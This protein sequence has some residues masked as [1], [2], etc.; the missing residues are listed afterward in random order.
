VLLRLAAAVAGVPVGLDDVLSGTALGPVWRRVA[1]LPQPRAEA[2]WVDARE[3]DVAVLLGLAGHSPGEQAAGYLR[4]VLGDHDAATRRLSQ[5]R[6]GRG[7][8]PGA[9]DGLL[10]EA[11]RRVLAARHPFADEVHPTRLERY[12]KCPFAFYLRDVLRLEAPEEP[13]EGLEMD[14]LELGTLAHAILQRTFQ[15][16]ICEHLD[17]PG[18]LAELDRSWQDACDQAERRGVTGAPLAW[19]ARRAA[20]RDDL[21]EAVRR[22]PV[23]ANDDG[24]PLQAERGFGRAHDLPV[25]LDLGDGRAVSFAGRIDR[26]DQV[27]GGRRVVD[28]KTGAGTSEEQRLKDALSVQLPVY[29]LA[30]RQMDQVG[31]PVTAEYRTVTRRGGFRRLELPGPDE[32]VLGRLRQLVGD[33]AALIDDGMF[34]RA[35]RERCQYCDLGYAC[36]VSEWSRSRKRGHDALARVVALQSRPAPDAEAADG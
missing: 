14:P 27:A 32:Q 6:S 23:F 28:Y 10:G 33:A 35:T 15:A 1:G 19:Q 30:V 8:T 36:G 17:L 24:V 20:L 7:T 4:E 25:T 2:V 3:R 29:L 22:D 9:W 31:G 21:R 12:I 18:A 16:V 5:W 11:S 26:V 13:D 34:P